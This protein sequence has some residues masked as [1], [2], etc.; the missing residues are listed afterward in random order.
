MLQYYIKNNFPPMNTLD[1]LSFH[2][3]QQQIFEKKNYYW[4]SAS[5]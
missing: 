4:S 3:I 5:F 2:P 1:F